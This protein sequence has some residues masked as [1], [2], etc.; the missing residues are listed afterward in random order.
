MAITISGSGITSANIADGTIVNA[1]VA[2]LAASKLTGAL[3]AIDGSALTNLSAGKVLQVLSTNKTSTFT[4][5]SA[6]FVDVTGLSVSIT[7]SSASSK[8]VVFLTTHIANTTSTATSNVRLMRDAIPISVG[9]A[10]GNRIASTGEF[11]GTWDGAVYH[12][13]ANYLDSPNT[14]SAIVYKLQLTTQSGFTATLNRAGVD[15]D[16]V[17]TGR[18]ASN[19]TVMEIGA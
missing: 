2:D 16:Y 4:T 5:T 13:G 7:P 1:D 6:S 3:P 19:I 15:N 8:I 14:T 9:V 12:I 11:G 10:D 17:N 18:Y